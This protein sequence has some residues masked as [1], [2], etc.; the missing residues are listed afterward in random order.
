MKGWM[1]QEQRR[2]TEWRL[3][4]GNQHCLDRQ[5]VRLHPQPFTTSSQLGKQSPQWPLTRWEKNNATRVAAPEQLTQPG[6]DEP[7][8]LNPLT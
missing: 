8:V 7:Q 6:A 1:A 4:T 2:F 5:Q 3:N